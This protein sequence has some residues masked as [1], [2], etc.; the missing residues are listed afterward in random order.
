MEEVLIPFRSETVDC[1]A[2]W[3]EI[4]VPGT[5]YIYEVPYVGGHLVENIL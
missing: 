5:V 1:R 2:K 4:W 3:S